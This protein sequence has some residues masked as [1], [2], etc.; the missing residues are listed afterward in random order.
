MAKDKREIKKDIL[1]M[2]RTLENE[3]GDVLPP[4]LLGSDYFKQLNWEEKRLYQSAVN[5]LISKFNLLI[6]FISCF[7]CF[8]D[9]II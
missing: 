4:E 1:D 8:R 9:N 3:D 7:S 6:I 2:F 5:D